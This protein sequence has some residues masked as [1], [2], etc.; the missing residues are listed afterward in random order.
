[1][2]GGQVGREGE[3]GKEGGRAGGQQA[4]RRVDMYAN[5]HR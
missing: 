3:G 5:I 2:V 4:E 1:M